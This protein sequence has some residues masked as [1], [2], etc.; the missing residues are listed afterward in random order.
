MICL[1]SR[2][3]LMR[4]ADRIAVTPRIISDDV[5]SYDLQI[6][7]TTGAILSEIA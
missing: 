3:L 7:L 4:L 6:P 1:N 2:R 5:E